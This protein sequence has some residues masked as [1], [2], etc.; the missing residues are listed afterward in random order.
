MPACIWQVKSWSTL[1]S[2]L[3][4]VIEEPTRKGALLDL[5]QE[6]K[7][8]KAR[9][10]KIRVSF[11]CSDHEMVE[12]RILRGGS[13]KQDHNPELEESRLQPLQRFAW[14]NPM[15]YSPGEKRGVGELVDIQRSSP[16]SSRK[17]YPNKQEIEQ[18]QQEA[19]T[20]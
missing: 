18:K 9:D 4:Q 8:E 20:D 3:T 16:P 17:V 6:N 12:F 13:K 2:F 7:E 19:H 15:G 11:G 14:K 1:T 5:I 10:V